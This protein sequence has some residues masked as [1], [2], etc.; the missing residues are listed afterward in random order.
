MND[1]YAK[2]QVH[3]GTEHKY[4]KPVTHAKQSV[5]IPSHM[6]G[7]RGGSYSC[8]TR[9]VVAVGTVETEHYGRKRVEYGKV[10][11]G[12]CVLVVVQDAG[13]WQTIDKRAVAGCTSKKGE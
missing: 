2:L 10:A 7:R 5:H 8:V 3:Y 6:L 12:G 11:Y 13:V 1:P 4:D 9:S